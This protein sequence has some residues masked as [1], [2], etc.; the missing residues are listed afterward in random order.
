VAGPETT[1][2]FSAIGYHYA[3]TLYK[4]LNVPVGIINTSQGPVK[5][6]LGWICQ[7]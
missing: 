1:G 6:T 7:H 3:L 5:S 2:D 4:V